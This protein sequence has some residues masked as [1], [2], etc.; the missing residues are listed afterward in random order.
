MPCKYCSARVVGS[1]TCGDCSQLV[2]RGAW[3]L[4]AHRW[5]TERPEDWVPDVAAFLEVS[6]GRT[7]P[8]HVGQ[9]VVP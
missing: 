6:E 3:N 2:H 1:T 5:L 9:V 8:S 4:L 7:E